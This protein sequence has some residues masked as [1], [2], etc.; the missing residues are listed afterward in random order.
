MKSL[1]KYI[2]ESIATPCSHKHGVSLFEYKG[3][4]IRN[5]ETSAG[6][7]DEIKHYFAQGWVHLKFSK[8]NA[9]PY[10]YNFK[11]D[12]IIIGDA[13]TI[14]NNLFIPDNED[15]LK[16]M[17]LD[18][19]DS[20]QQ[21]RYCCGIDDDTELIDN[22]YEENKQYI[23]FTFDELNKFVNLVK[24]TNEEFKPYITVKLENIREING[25]QLAD[26]L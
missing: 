15:K 8:D 5:E 3:H 18:G 19:V 12:K 11:L 22:W 16:E 9:Y 13:N 24:K 21:L 4:A 2:K 1:V 17:G 20:V 10:I 26:A 25:L 23:D 6:D 7:P 14:H